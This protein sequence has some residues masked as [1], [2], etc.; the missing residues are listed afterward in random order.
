MPT[1]TARAPTPPPGADAAASKPPPEGPP[2]PP[3]PRVALAVRSVPSDG[4]DW[5]ASRDA[6]ARRLEHE[7]RR[8]RVSPPSGSAAGAW[9]VQSSLRHEVSVPGLGPLSS[10]RSGDAAKGFKLRS[11]RLKTRVHKHNKPKKYPYETLQRT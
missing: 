5:G 1:A 4:E 7:P 8:E 10:L 2:A 11:E 9:P 3:A 6:F